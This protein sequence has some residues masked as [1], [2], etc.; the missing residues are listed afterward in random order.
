MLALAI[1]PSV[2]LL[3]MFSSFVAADGVAKLPS[4][5]NP[6]TAFMPFAFGGVHTQKGNYD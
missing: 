4:G 3:S 1:A 6:G 5:T 2:L